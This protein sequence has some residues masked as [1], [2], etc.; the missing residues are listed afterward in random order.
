MHDRLQCHVAFQKLVATVNS[1]YASNKSFHFTFSSLTRLS[2]RRLL[3]ISRK[4]KGSR[5]VSPSSVLSNSVHHT[6]IICVRRF[7]RITSIRE[8]RSATQCSR[9]AY[10]SKLRRSIYVRTHSRFDLA[11]ADSE[12]LTAACILARRSE[13]A[14]VVYAHV[15][16]SSTAREMSLY[17]S[18]TLFVLSWNEMSQ[19]HTIWV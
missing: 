12:S 11:L 3:V 16:R 15:A 13:N 18:M 2:P 5:L 4:G 19:G 14:S 1:A 6:W 10:P 7:R 9:L 8:S 17:R